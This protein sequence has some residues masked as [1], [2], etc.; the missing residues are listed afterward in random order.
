M[1]QQRLELVLDDLVGGE[2]VKPSS[3]PVGL[4]G[5]FRIGIVRDQ[6]AFDPVAFA[7]MVAKGRKAWADV[8]DAGLWVDQ[9]R[10]NG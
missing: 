10:G 4:L 5:G 2:P 7:I 3:M 9:L 6:L 8:P 1:A